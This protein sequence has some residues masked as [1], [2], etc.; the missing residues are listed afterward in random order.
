MKFDFDL[1]N[2]K[3]FGATY[4][5]MGKEAA[6]EL[7]ER[8]KRESRIMNDQNKLARAQRELGALVYSLAK[9]GE[10]N[11][12]L[13]DKYIDTIDSLEQEI[14]QLRAMNAPKP[15]EDDNTVTVEFDEQVQPEAPVQPETAAQPEANAPQQDVQ[16]N[17]RYCS[18]CGK[19]VDEDAL[20][21]DH[22]GAQL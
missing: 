9:N 18:R 16:H 12:P 22:C 4:A 3:N 2:L 1:D 5:E 21:C 20:F 15:V 13:V 17:A 10:N 7:A 11:Q 14:Q 6:T 19:Q 8:V